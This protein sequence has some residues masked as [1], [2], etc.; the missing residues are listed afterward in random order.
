MKEKPLKRGYKFKN[1]TNI[2]NLSYENCVELLDPEDWLII[3]EHEEEI[4]RLGHFKKIFPL[5]KNIHKF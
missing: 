3:F 1:S 4:D 5:G 2:H